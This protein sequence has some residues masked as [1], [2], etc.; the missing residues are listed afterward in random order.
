MIF[1]VET[2]DKCIWV[3]NWECPQCRVGLEPK[4]YEL[5]ERKCSSCGYVAVEIIFIRTDFIP[6]GLL[7]A[8]DEVTTEPKTGTIKCFNCKSTICT[9][10][11]AHVNSKEYRSMKCV[12]G[13]EHS[14][15]PAAVEFGIL[16][17]F[18]EMDI[19]G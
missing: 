13:F 15:Y 6:S 17:P 3:L 18:L 4:P 9:S 11:W 19:S 7:V 16:V 12:S 1:K 2:I 8:M 10:N 5:E 14:P